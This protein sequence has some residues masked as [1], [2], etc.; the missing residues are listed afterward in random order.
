M[1]SAAS[2]SADFMGHERDIAPLIEL[3]EMAAKKWRS[4][5]D[6]VSETNYFAAIKFY[7]K[8]GRKPAGAQAS[9]CVN[10]RPE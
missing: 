5:G 4:E 7:S 2:Q 10:F 1:F 9:E 3:L 6:D 8:C